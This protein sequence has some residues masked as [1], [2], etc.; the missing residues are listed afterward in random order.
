MLALHPDEKAGIRLSVEDSQFNVMCGFY[1]STY[2]LPALWHA[3]TEASP[4]IPFG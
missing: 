1:M 2:K 4:V 3:S